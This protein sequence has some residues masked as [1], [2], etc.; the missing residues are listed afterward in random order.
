[1]KSNWV[2]IVYIDKAFE[3]FYCHL[4]YSTD[5][6]QNIHHCINKAKKGKKLSYV[7]EQIAQKNG[8]NN[9]FIVILYEQTLIL[10]VKAILLA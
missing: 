7:D 2:I 5:N 3:V 4:F 1:M 10:R 9:Q 6:I 8:S